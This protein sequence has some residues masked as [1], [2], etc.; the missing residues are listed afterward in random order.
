LGLKKIEETNGGYQALKELAVQAS[1][2]E[3]YGEAV[4]IWQKALELNPNDA[5]ACMNAGYAYFKVENFEAAHELSKKALELDPH[6]REAA[7]NLSGCELMLDNAGRAI[8]L[9]EGILAKE[10]DYP[11]AMGR[12]A[13]A[14]ILGGRQKEGLE[15]LRR[16]QQR[17]YNCYA[18]IDEQARA[19]SSLG[20]GR[21][22][23]LLME[24][25]AKISDSALESHPVAI[26]SA[27]A[28][29]FRSVPKGDPGAFS[30]VPRGQDA[31]LNSSSC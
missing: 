31:Q 18:L 1:E 30:I 8:T 3:E 16:L 11:P 24:A 15:Y 25:V 4:K 5:V 6:L 19:L 2:L 9:L 26:G 17:N 10:P 28:P 7:L 29:D 20:K 12:I 21:E 23:S 14:Y 27:E 13:A 22:A